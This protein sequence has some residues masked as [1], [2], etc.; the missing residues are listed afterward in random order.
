MLREVGNP[1]FAHPIQSYECA[2][3]HINKLPEEII[4]RIFSYLPANELDRSRLVCRLW[5][6]IGSENNLWKA[7]FYREFPG[8]QL[9]GTDIRLEYNI[10]HV[11]IRA[12]IVAKRASISELKDHTALILS[13][14]FS[15]DG[16]LLATGSFDGTARIWDIFTN[17]CLFTLNHRIIFNPRGDVL[18]TRFSPDGKLL[19]TGCGKGWL[20]FWNV[21]LGHL[22]FT[23][24]CHQGAIYS[25][26]FSPDGS[27][28]VSASCDRTVGVWDVKNRKSQFLLAHEFTPFISVAFSSNGKMV[29]AASKSVHLWN[30][31]TRQSLMTY[32]PLESPTSVV[33]SSDSKELIAGIDKR[34]IEIWN[35]DLE[36]YIFKHSYINLVCTDFI[37]NISIST[38]GRYLVSSSLVG[39]VCFLDMKKRN[40]PKCLSVIATSAPKHFAIFSPDS[41][42]VAFPADHKVL[43]CDFA[44][45]SNDINKTCVFDP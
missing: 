18:S 28:L 17:K 20:R 44:S 38:N 24:G 12:N 26:D 13:G 37:S 9:C 11:Q 39:T 36:R 1:L 43:I 27:Q 34:R 32:T 31:S 16:K 45:Q 25:I 22:E 14:A 33:F 5:H 15:P 23:L 35:I 3:P 29:A 8:E 6:Q 42:K 30:L 10:R 41:R 19:A 40:S 2:E 4:V 21:A 7:L